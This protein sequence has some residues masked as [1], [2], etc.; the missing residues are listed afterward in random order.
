MN[1]V[2]ALRPR[3]FRDCGVAATSRGYVVMLW[4]GT[5]QRM[6]SLLSALRSNGKPPEEAWRHWPPVTSV[7]WRISAGRPATLQCDVCRRKWL[8]DVA[9]GGV[10]YAVAFC[11]MTR[12]GVM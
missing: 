3:G 12:Y 6:T 4:H 10:V 11:S 7:L 9:G 1:G 5:R 2:V 8:S